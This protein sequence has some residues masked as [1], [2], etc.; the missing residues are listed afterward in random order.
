MT[1]SMRRTSAEQD[2]QNEIKKH[3]QHN[4]ASQPTTNGKCI[5]YCIYVLVSEQ[6]TIE[7][8]NEETQKSD[9]Y[10]DKNQS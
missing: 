1:R 5:A 4:P 8:M 7:R 10:V 6:T 3:L 2:E 9:Q